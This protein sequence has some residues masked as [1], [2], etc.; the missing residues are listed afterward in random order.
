MSIASNPRRVEFYAHSKDEVRPWEGVEHAARVNEPSQQRLGES[1]APQRP[2]AIV[3]TSPESTIGAI[4]NYHPC[5]YV[6]R[7]MP[8]FQGRPAAAGLVISS[9]GEAVWWLV[10]LK[11][12]RETETT[13]CGAQEVAHGCG[14]MEHGVQ[15]H[16]SVARST[17]DG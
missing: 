12:A 11:V 13:T 2:C 5:P 10:G 16:L 15:C 4:I 6:L 9:V 8:A 1:F 14:P 3:Q 7:T 17:N